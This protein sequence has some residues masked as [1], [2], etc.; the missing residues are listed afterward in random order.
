MF[1]VDLTIDRSCSLS[2]MWSREGSSAPTLFELTK[3]FKP[4]S[5]FFLILSFNP[6]SPSFIQRGRHS[7]K[8]ASPSPPTPPLPL[9]SSCGGDMEAGVGDEERDS[10]LPLP[11]LTYGR[12]WSK[13]LVAGRARCAKVEARE[14]PAKRRQ[15]SSF[16]SSFTFR[17]LCFLPSPLCLRSG[18]GVRVPLSLASPPKCTPSPLLQYTSKSHLNESPTTTAISFPSSSSSPPS[19]ATSL[20]ASPIRLR[21][22]PPCCNS[23]PLA[24]PPLSEDTAGPEEWGR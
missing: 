13:W 1:F 16:L 4:V 17:R 3:V 11:C 21:L 7:S 19:S 6:F 15:S 23:S 10:R 22:L 14:L 18:V 2:S 20:A 24:S 5:C 12:E 8:P 9:A